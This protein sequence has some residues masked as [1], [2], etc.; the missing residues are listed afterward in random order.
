MSWFGGGGGG[1]S[2]G[3]FEK[4]FEEL[5]MGAMQK[6]QLD[7][8]SHTS[9]KVS[10]RPPPPASRLPRLRPP[11]SRK[12][13]IGDDHLYAWLPTIGAPG[14]SSHLHKGCKVPQPAPVS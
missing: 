6:Q 13:E 2:Q 9:T 3:E 1:G 11:P 14:I 4:R 5:L 7:N 12:R 10:D 8:I